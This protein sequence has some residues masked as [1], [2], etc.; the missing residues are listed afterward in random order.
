MRVAFISYHTSPLATLGGK[1]TGGMNVFV[2]ETA[3]EMAR[4]GILVDVY[5][6][7]TSPD[8]KQVDDVLAP[9]V[10]VIHV[11]A[12]P[13]S[14]VA[15]AELRKYVP[16]FVE[17]VC[18]FSHAETASGLLKGS[19]HP[20]ATSIYDVVHAHYWLSGL[21]AEQLTTCWGAK[22]VQ[23]FHTLAELKT[24]LRC[25]LKTWKAMS[26]FR[27]NATCANVLIELPPQPR[28]NGVNWF[29]STAPAAVGFE[30]S[31]LALI[32]ACLTTSPKAMPAKQSACRSM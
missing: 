2:R 17:Q 26:V 4:R 10:R 21:A 31:R 12:G 18:E 7:K 16:E 1:D 14:A 3:R 19:S 27:R 8:Q 23:T 5:V 29:T 22:F 25:A 13:P 32:L 20:E 6:R 9:G 11:S 28:L 30:L 24:R 15:K